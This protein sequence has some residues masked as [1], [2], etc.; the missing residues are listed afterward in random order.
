VEVI[1]DARERIKGASQAGPR[2][3]ILAQLDYMDR[4]TKITQRLDRCG[5]SRLRFIGHGKKINSMVAAQATEEVEAAALPP[6]IRREGKIGGNDG[7]LHR[8]TS[9]L[10][11]HC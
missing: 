5:I 2:L 7:D 3:E 4:K 1:N 11:E 8:L 6:G 9:L 10:R